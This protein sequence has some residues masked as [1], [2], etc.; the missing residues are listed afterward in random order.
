[1][2]L[3][4]TYDVTHSTP[5][6][7]HTHTHTLTRACTHVILAHTHTHMTTASASITVTWKPATVTRWASVMIGCLTSLDVTAH[8]VGGTGGVVKRGAA[9]AADCLTGPG[10]RRYV[11]SEGTSPS[12]WVPGFASVPPR[13]SVRP[14]ATCSTPSLSAFSSPD[15]PVHTGV[16]V[17]SNTGHASKPPPYVNLDLHSIHQW[18]KFDY[19][20]VKV[21]WNF[22]N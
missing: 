9:C 13:M 7:P 2:S 11:K 8:W 16:Q 6:H 5:S 3:S 14:R 15:L 1:M 10:S 12:P 18:W 20:K 4:D 22:G 21:I 19:Y 17:V